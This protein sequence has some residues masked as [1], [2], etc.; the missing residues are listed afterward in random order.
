[1]LR[2][3]VSGSIPVAK[4]AVLL[5]RRNISTESK[6]LTSTGRPQQPQPPAVPHNEPI[7]PMDFSPHIEWFEYPKEIFDPKYPYT[8]E[9]SIR[10]TE[11][12]WESTMDEMASR[13]GMR[14][15]MST[16][17]TFWLAWSIMVFYSWYTLWGCYRAMGTEPG[18]SHFRNIVLSQP[19]VPTLEEDDIYLDQWIRPEI[20]EK[21]AK[22]ER[23]WNWK[24]LVKRDGAQTSWKIPMQYQDES[25]WRHMTSEN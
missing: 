11:E 4:I 14:L 5:S 6:D 13:Y 21:H 2:R 15:N 23:F 17:P 9:E 16:K 18:W 20:R 24:P 12:S 7:L 8:R 22:Y 10:M 19:N 1:M 3:V 25:E